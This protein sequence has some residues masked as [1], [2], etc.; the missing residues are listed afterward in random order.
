MNINRGFELS[1]LDTR[2]DWMS[3]TVQGFA[4]ELYLMYR[5]FRYSSTA[6]LLRL[7][8]QIFVAGSLKIQENN[9]K[10]F[11]L[12]SPQPCKSNEPG[13]GA[14]EL[15]QQLLIDCPQPVCFQ[16]SHKCA[17]F[18]PTYSCL[19][20]RLW[21]RNKRRRVEINRR[22]HCDKSEIRKYA[23]S[24]KNDPNPTW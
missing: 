7:R 9:C 14:I 12:F 1:F 15:C 5:C 22:K 6:G 21:M 10:S 4:Q 13:C 8:E 3:T 19:P 20:S 11:E 23:G 2:V 17:S 18:L 16:L 24:C